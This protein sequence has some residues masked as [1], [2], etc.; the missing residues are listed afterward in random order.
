M[1]PRPVA[2]ALAQGRLTA[3]RKPTGKLRGIVTGA[4]IR[5]V[6]AKTLAS[7]FADAIEHTTAPYQFALRTRA[8]TDALAF[9][10]RT[11]TD[12]DPNAVIL[13][14]DGIGAYDHIRRRAML[15][16]LYD[17]PELQTLLPFMRQFYGEPSEY[18]WTDDGGTTHHIP[19]GEGGEQGDPLMP[20][21]YALGQHDGL[22]AGVR[23]LHPDD[24]VVAYLDDLYVRAT[25][26]RAVCVGAEANVSASSSYPLVGIA[27]AVRLAAEDVSRVA[28]VFRPTRS[29]SAAMRR[30]VGGKVSRS[31]VCTQSAVS[32]S[33]WLWSSSTW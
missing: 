21:L 9:A 14:L 31:G 12:K 5:R 29:H 10:L 2:R 8:G 27:A 26:E 28:S 6:V 24:F 16:K 17:T 25:R 18:L 7:Q 30:C 19:Q 4:T 32:T 33:P 11:A 3:L 15:G 22:E 1:V 20:A 13:S 23:Q